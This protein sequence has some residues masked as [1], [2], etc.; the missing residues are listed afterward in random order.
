MMKPHGI[1]PPLVTPLTADGELDLARQRELIERHIAAGV[2]GIFVLGTTGEFY[3]LDEAE[4]QA[5]VASA[6]AAVNGRVPVLAG[7]G[8]E[9]TRE[10]VRL[11]RMAERE[12]A[13]GASVIT[14]YYIRPSQAEV[15]DHF[16]GV[17][18]ATSKAV[19][20]YSNPGPCNGLR[21]AP[22]TVARLAELNNVVGIKD[23]AGDLEA[24]METVRL[25]PADF[26]VMTG[27]D[28]LILSSMQLGAVGSVPAT[29]NVAP[30]PFVELYAA[31]AGGDFDTARRLQRRV[32]GLR[33][34]LTLGVSPGVIK[35]AMAEAGQP[36]GPARPPLRPP[37]E[38]AMRA[39]RA[40]VSEVLSG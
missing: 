33:R 32:A 11:T 6:V 1:I 39:V 16:R 35:A 22:E 21:I 36:A 12:G 26:S 3:A 15:E 34:L 7:T 4:K 14:P 40:A 38:A 19:V 24:I 37:D 13:D 20:L 28:P 27:R 30:R 31:A 8:A 17:A 9:A 18:E 23:S 29:S 10:A 5:V 25:V 2:H